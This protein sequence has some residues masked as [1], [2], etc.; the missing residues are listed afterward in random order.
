MAGGWRGCCSYGHNDT[1]IFRLTQSAG[2]S[3][4]QTLT[5]IPPSLPNPA[6]TVLTMPPV[7]IQLLQVYQL[8]LTMLLSAHLSKLP[9]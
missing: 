6:Q 4:S 5:Q 9:I 2:E 8:L 3:M 1:D 7:A